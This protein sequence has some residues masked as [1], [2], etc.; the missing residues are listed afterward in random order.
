[1]FSALTIEQLGLAF[2]QLLQGEA[3]KARRELGHS[4]DKAKLKVGVVE[5]ETAENV[6]EEATEEIYLVVALISVHGTK[7]YAVLD[8]CATPNVIYP[9]LSK[10]LCFTCQQ[11]RKF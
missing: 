4:F 6:L 7:F 5:E 11:T 9:A 2:G 8:T 3:N 1:M 10:H